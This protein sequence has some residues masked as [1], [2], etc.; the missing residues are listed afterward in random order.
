MSFDFDTPIDRRGSDSLKWSRYAG[1]DVVPLWVA[2]M[3]FAAPPAVLDALHHRIDHG[4]FGYAKAWPSLMEAVQDHLQGEYGWQ[5]EPSWIVWIPGVVAAFNV[6]CR[7]VGGTG[8]GVFTT[9]PVYP[10]F[11]T[12][13]EHS[14]RHLVTLPLVRNGRR[15]QW[16]FAATDKAL[17]ESRARLWLLCHPHNPVGRVWNEDELQEIA[18]LAE[19]HDLVVCSDEIHCGLVLDPATK[20]KPLAALSPAMAKRTIT[21]MA[22]SKTFN[23]PA[24]YSA[25][26]VIPDPALRRAFSRVMD[27]IMPHINT[28]GLVATEAAYRDCGEWHGALIDYLRGNARRVEET[29]ATMPGLSVTPVEATYLAWID[30]RELCAAKGIDNPQRFFE[31]AGVGLSDGCD[32]GLPSFVRLNFGCPRATLDE[33]LARMAAAIN[34]L[35]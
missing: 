9:T 14:G 22:P 10:P 19:K 23:I 31:K 18:R 4:V 33:G 2:D 20:H 27:G 26:A 29:V 35:P 24:L 8:A 12:A 3:D 34:A 11:L 6:A 5:I 13:P 25:F 15:W 1:R 7:A 17:A 30:C 32:F 16:D 21:L 28:L